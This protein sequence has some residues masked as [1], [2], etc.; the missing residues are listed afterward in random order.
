[1]AKWEVHENLRGGNGMII[2][3]TVKVMWLKFIRLD[4]DPKASIGHHLHDGDSELYITFNK[5][6]RFCR[7]PKWKLLNFCKKGSAHS[8]ENLSELEDARIWAVKF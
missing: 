8:A 3:R 2:T 1:M 6:I 4:L 7:N 5:N